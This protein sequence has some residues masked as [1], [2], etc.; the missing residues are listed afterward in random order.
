MRFDFVNNKFIETEN[1]SDRL[2]IAGTDKNLSEKEVYELHLKLKQQLLDLKIPIGHPVIIFGEKEALF[3]IAMITLIS[4]NIPYIPVDAIMPGGRIEKIK[5]LSGSKV[6]INCSL[7]KCKVAFEIQIQ[8]DLETSPSWG[9]ELPV[10][11]APANDP[12]RYILFT[13]GSTGEPKGVQITASAFNS[14]VKWYKDWPGINSEAVFMNQAPFS[15]DISLCDFIGLFAFGATLIL[16]DYSVLKSGPA[17]LNRLARYNAN[18]IVCTPSF[19]QMYLTVPDFK[20]RTYPHL[21][22]IIFIG[23][24]LPAITAK[25]L[26][27]AFPGLKIVNAYGPTEATVVTT[28]I[29][30][31]EDILNQ[32]PRSLPIGY[33]R[34]DGEMLVL[35]SSGN[36]EEEGELAIVGDHVSIGYLNNKEKNDAAFFIHNGKRAYKTGDHGFIKNNII[37]FLG[38]K[39]DQIKLNGYRIE[40]DEIASVILKHPKIANT[41]VVPLTSGNTVKKLIAFVIL[42]PNEGSD[43]LNSELKGFLSKSLSSYMIP[44]EFIALSEFPL[45]SNYKTNKKALV[46]IYMNL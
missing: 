20:E 3:P 23:E 35:N 34:A 29:E 10:I 9:F 19:I 8:N 41:A 14:F 36:P 15:F 11:P 4:L 33:G 18:T 43:D 37:F 24:E 7:E 39:D 38:R 46:E 45:N 1:L 26:K 28:Y 22:Q 27:V 2:F 13:S 25:K 44:S 30:I 32:Y 17:F 5:E 21:K 31:T 6:L 40:L 16:N 12:L 42:K